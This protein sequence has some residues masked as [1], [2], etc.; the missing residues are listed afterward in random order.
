MNPSRRAFFSD[1]GKGLIVAGL[2]AGL[3]TDLGVNLAFAE[4]KSNELAFGDLEPLVRLLQDTEANK[5]TPILVERLHN[6]TELKTLVAAAALANARTFGGEDYVGFH[7]M[8]ALAPAYEIARELPEA[9]R[10]L[11]VLKVLYRNSNRIR[12]KGG[13]KAEVLKAVEPT[14]NA[15]KLRDDYRLADEIHAKNADKAE[16]MLGRLAQFGPEGALNGLLAVVEEAAEVHRIVLM[17][18][19][20]DMLNIVGKE[21]A[22]TMLRQSVRYCIKSEGHAYMNRFAVIRQ[23]VPK[24]LDENRLEGKSVGTKTGDLAWVMDLG[25]VVFRSTPEQAAGAVAK[26]IADGYS[27]SAIGEAIRLAA[28][29][30]VLRDKGRPKGQTAPGKPEGSCHGDSIGVHASDSANAWTNLARVADAR[31]GVICLMLGAWQVAFD[32]TERGGDFLNWPTHPT[33]EE[34]DK[35]ADTAGSDA[36]KLLAATEAAIKAKD[37][38]GAAAAAAN[39]GNAKADV[40]PAAQVR[41]QRGRSAARGEVLPHGER[42]VCDDA[43]RNAVETR[44]VFGAGDRQRVRT[45]RTGPGRGA[46]FVEGVMECWFT[47]RV[48]AARTRNV[49]IITVSPYTPPRP[50]RLPEPSNT[51]APPASL[52]IPLRTAPPNPRPRSTRALGTRPTQGV[53]RGTSTSSRGGLCRSPTRV[54]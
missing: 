26:A 14:P 49:N 9:E 39:Y 46:A 30:L 10:P 35:V 21:H 36:A 17:W 52:P 53:R 22:H 11:P 6:G 18:R 34:S 8:M 27:A 20:W 13:R 5:L 23:I 4:E 40:R 1:V 25:R 41:H 51:V 29:E 31:N 3:A 2:G 43:V 54:P 45:T 44:R 12:E 32:R 19:A 24:L 38:V 7:T 50:T 48:R 33:G 42:V 37:Q 47:F 28:N 15:S 16:A